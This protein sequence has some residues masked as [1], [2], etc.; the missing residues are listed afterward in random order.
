MKRT[1]TS[2]LCRAAVAVVVASCFLL[3]APAFSQAISAPGSFSVSQP[4]LYSIVDLG[5]IGGPHP[6]GRVSIASLNKS[7]QIAGYFNDIK[8]TTHQL[9]S[10]AFTWKDGHTT[11]LPPLPGFLYCTA[12]AQ[13]DSGVV[14]GQSHNNIRDVKVGGRT[15]E[16]GGNACA[17]A[18]EAGKP[19]RLKAQ[20]AGNSG[21][22]A[23]NGQGD[24]AGQYTVITRKSYTE[25]ACLWR[26]GGGFT[27]LGPA[28]ALHGKK[29][30]LGWAAMRINDQGQVLG[31]IIGSE[32]EKAGPTLVFWEKGYARL[33]TMQ[34]RHQMLQV[35]NAH[36]Q[37]LRGAELV[38]EGK[39]IPLRWSGRPAQGLDLND[40]GQVVGG[41][42]A[43][44]LNLPPSAQRTAY[45]DHAFLWEAGQMHDLNDQVSVVKG[46]ILVEAL[47]ID[48][49]GRILVWASR[50]MD[51]RP[52]LLVP[53]SK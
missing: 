39:V 52:I 25:H 20:G 48:E 22:N 17:C 41:V 24:I 8:G 33:A 1:R 10:Q 16:E 30:S 26:H 19:R 27:D 21:A 6:F 50:P 11:L 9:T 37:V 47:N 40:M 2:S 29:S 34:D 44:K 7:G 3:R 53:V 49:Q 32:E 43:V 23:V 35:K 42:P 15:V 38:S 51:D 46:W 28:P 13:N 12:S 14:V 4:P 18:W 45:D 36:G 5:T 31:E